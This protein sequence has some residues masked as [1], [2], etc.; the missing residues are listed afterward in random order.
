MFICHP[1]FIS[2][3]DSDCPRVHL[4]AS[5]LSEALKPG[6]S[7][8][9]TGCSII[10]CT[11]PNLSSC[12]TWWKDMMEESPHKYSGHPSLSQKVRPWT[13]N[14]YT[15]WQVQLT[16]LQFIPEFPS[17]CPMLHLWSVTWP[18]SI[19]G[20]SLRHHVWMVASSCKMCMQVLCQ[21]CSRSQWAAE[22][23]KVWVG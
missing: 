22:H 16:W 5:W 2:L 6:F 15:W 12:W 19:S 1:S 13:G 4:W 9:H 23:G 21:N 18:G 8:Q 17:S 14:Q 20:R 7:T 3:R 11:E 10:C